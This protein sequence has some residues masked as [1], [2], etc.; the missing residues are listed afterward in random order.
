MNKILIVSKDLSNQG[1][2]VDFV[3][4]TLKYCSDNN[5]YQHFSIGN[6]PS[7]KSNLLQR[8][9]AADAIRLCIKSWCQKWDCIHMNTSFVW[10]SLVR[11]LAI[12]GIITIPKNNN[13]LIFIHGWNS[14]VSEVFKSNFILKNIISSIL[15]RSSTILVL[16]SDFKDELSTMG[17]DSNKIHVTTT[18]F[19][20]SFLKNTED[21]RDDK[22]TVILFL[23]RF[24]K[25]KGVYELLNAFKSLHEKTPTY[26]LMLA[27]DGPEKTNMQNYVYENNLQ[28]NVEFCG[29]VRDSKKAKILKS[30]DIFVFPTYYGEGCPVSLLEAMAAGLPIITTPVGGI[31]DIFINGKHGI[32][33]NEVSPKSIRIAIESLLSNKEQLEKIRKTNTK[34]AWEK[35][36]ASIVTKY[37]EKM[38][39]YVISQK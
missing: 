4:M 31:K 14:N 29:F 3:A 27:G 18:M 10:K 37:I 24:V 36:E 23:S 30:A 13:I 9:V 1:G 20:G 11:D 2:V 7:I 6:S 39:E 21:K 35:Y 5:H 22:N 28:D 32:L 33:L 19:D 15:N 25:E 8:N 12:I 38:Y 16:A 34:T 26:K 17:V